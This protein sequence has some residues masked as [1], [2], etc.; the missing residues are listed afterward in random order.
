M[1][2]LT[3]AVIVCAYTL[4][5]WDEICAA[6]TSAANQ[7]PQPDE[8]LLVVDHNEDLLDRARDELEQAMPGLRVVPSTRRKGLSGARNTGV[9]CASAD[10]VVFLDDDAEAADGWLRALTEPYRMSTVMAVGGVA[11]PRWPEGKARPVTLPARSGDERG[12]L[13]WIVGCT[14]EGQPMEQQPVRNLMGCNMSFRRSVFA[15]IGGF[16]ETLGRVGKVPLGCE[17]TEFCIRV[18]AHEPREVIIFEPAAKVRHKVSPDRLTWAYLRR[19]SYAEGLSKAAL[20]SMVGQDKALETERDYA[21][22][23]LPRALA[24]ELSRSVRPSPVAVRRGLSGTAAIVL[25]LAATATGYIRAKAVR[26]ELPSEAP[27]V[28]K[29]AP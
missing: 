13:D 16:A 2:S 10:L 27:P 15:R 21:V 20:V 1:S 3:T 23:V 18:R 7:S 29:L 8:L 6:L 12:E 11:Y 14:Y 5:R 26:V 4:D 28:L 24:R 9:E 22:K 19:R 17:E 25:A